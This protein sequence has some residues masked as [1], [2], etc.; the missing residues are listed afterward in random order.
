MSLISVLKRKIDA[1]TGKR[2]AD[3][4]EAAF[5]AARGKLVERIRKLDV[6]SEQTAVVTRRLLAAN[7]VL[8]SQMKAVI[9]S[10]DQE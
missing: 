8:I 2:L 4:R 1:A 10:L 7:G 6:V 5:D 9:D 3:E